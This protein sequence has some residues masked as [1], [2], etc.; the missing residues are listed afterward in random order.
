MGP[1]ECSGDEAI[2][3]THASSYGE[4]HGVCVRFYMV[5]MGPRECSG[6]EAI[7]EIYASSYGESHGVRVRFY[8]VRMGFRRI[9]GGG[10]MDPTGALNPP[11]D[12]NGRLKSPGGPPTGALNPPADLN[13]RLKSLADLNRSLKSPVLKW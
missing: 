2:R 6:G 11:A 4:S 1:R 10:A 5:R 7:R 13:G 12:L 8:M 9:S 3:E